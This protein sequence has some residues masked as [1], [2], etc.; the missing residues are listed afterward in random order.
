MLMAFPTKMLPVNQ[1]VCCC[2]MRSAYAAQV[3]AKHVPEYD[4]NSSVLLLLL[5]WRSVEALM[6]RAMFPKGC[7]YGPRPDPWLDAQIVLSA[8]FS[9]RFLPFPR[10][11]PHMPC[12]FSPG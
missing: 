3:P 12:P 10:L 6:I 9:F 7:P 8:A 11:L 4:S 2:S 5:S 1:H